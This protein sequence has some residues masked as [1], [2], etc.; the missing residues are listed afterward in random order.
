[1]MMA[2]SAFIR[3]SGPADATSPRYFPADFTIGT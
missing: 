2:F 3:V 1:M